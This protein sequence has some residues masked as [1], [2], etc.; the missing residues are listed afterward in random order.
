MKRNGSD[1]LRFLGLAA[2]MLAFTTCT[3]FA[4][5]IEVGGGEPAGE[6]AP[7]RMA[8][9]WRVR[10]SLWDGER[11]GF[12]IEPGAPLHQGAHNYRWSDVAY[13]PYLGDVAFLS[14]AL[15]QREVLRIVAGEP[16]VLERTTPVMTWTFRHPELQD[17][18]VVDVSPDANMPIADIDDSPHKP[19][20]KLPAMPT[21]ELF[22]SPLPWLLLG[23]RT[24]RPVRNAAPPRA[25]DSRRTPG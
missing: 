8:R 17:L 19:P 21:L 15:V 14:R 16:T 2:A 4:F 12:C 11:I 22:L 5:E 10:S 20:T 7:G 18:L 23:R 6:Y 24:R 3:A 13:S 1:R 9:Y 25:A